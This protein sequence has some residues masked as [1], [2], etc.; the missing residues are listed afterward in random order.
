MYRI[1]SEISTGLWLVDRRK[2]SKNG[3]PGIAESRRALDASRGTI[4]AKLLRWYRKHRRSLPWR[5]VRDPYRIWLSEVMLQQTQ[6][7]QAIP[8]YLRFLKTFP[9]LDKLA[10]ASRDEILKLWEGLGYYRRA[11][12]LHETAKIIVRDYRGE[13][14]SDPAQLAQLPG[15]G[16]Y[17]VG[18]VASIAFGHRLPAV[19]GN[20]IRVIARLYCITQDASRSTTKKRIY[21][22]VRTLIPQRH[23]GHFAQALMELGAMVCTPRNARCSSCPLNTLCTANS[24]LKDVSILPKK[25]PRLH[26]PHYHVA[27]G[28]VRKGQLVLIARRPEGALLGGLWEFPGGKQKSGETMDEACR[29]ELAEETGLS[30]KLLGLR[31]IIRHE[32]SH[33]RVTL[34]FFDC[35]YD[36]GRTTPKQSAEM[37][38]VTI[39]ELDNFAFPKANKRIVDELVGRRR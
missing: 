39:K 1:I 24:R 27:V 15:F 30:V 32:Y 18:A 20:V 16:S 7:E 34:H 38:W 35:K 26:R 17:T 12:Y 5:N 13:F 37:R 22:I 36:G 14:P 11:T 23:P 19:D 29:R 25:K 28:I 2:A 33:F 4:S 9:T 6:V 8:Y 10:R 3:P 21:D 31:R